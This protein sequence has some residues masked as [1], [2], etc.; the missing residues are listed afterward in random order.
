MKNVV[1]FDFDGTLADT[2]EILLQ[3][4]NGL[5]DEFGYRAAPT[6]AEIAALRHLNSWQIIKQSGISIFKLPFLLRR[7]RIELEKEL[8]NVQLFPQI[9]P[10]LLELKQQDYRLGIITSNSEEIVRSVL[11]RE[12]LISTFEF[13]YS[14]TS[15]FA[16][17]KVINRFLNQE[18]LES[19]LVIYV[20]D[21]TRDIEAAQK[22][23][24]KMIAVAW[25]FNSSDILKSYHPDYL[26]N[27]P[28]EIWEVLEK[29]LVVN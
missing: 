14:G 10:V 2:L 23:Q 11:L 25:G 12:N 7:V 21:E 6:E 13:I 28:Q 26:I 1:I 20:G 3:I 5:A 29:K 22:S 19:N 17:H 27:H 16:K 18:S 8:K 24:I 4:T 9:K 15:L